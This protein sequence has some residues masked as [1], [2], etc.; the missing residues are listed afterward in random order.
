MKLWFLPEFEGTGARGHIIFHPFLRA[1][2]MK[3][4]NNKLG[5]AIYIHT[6]LCENGS[7]S[8]L[9]Y[10]LLTV[11]TL[12]KICKMTLLLILLMFH[13]FHLVCWQRVPMLPWRYWDAH[14]D[15]VT[16]RQTLL[17]QDRAFILCR[18]HP[19]TGYRD[20]T[21][22]M[23]VLSSCMHQMPQLINLS[24]EALGVCVCI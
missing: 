12:F 11:S 5:S 21:L 16:N 20:P 9:F 1:E 24:I 4:L 3:G 2:G 7:V 18:R 10:V 15:K 19:R 6:K 13:C 22:L 23:Y 8:N 14:Q 17:L